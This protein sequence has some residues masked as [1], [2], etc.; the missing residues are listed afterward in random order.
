MNTELSTSVT[1]LFDSFHEIMC[2]FIGNHSRND[3][4]FSEC[5]CRRREKFI[6]EDGWSEYPIIFSMLKQPRMVSDIAPGFSDKL[7]WT[8][9]CIE[10]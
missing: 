10:V 8:S 7:N 5:P 6:S 9:A 4:D 1:V 2:S 3:I